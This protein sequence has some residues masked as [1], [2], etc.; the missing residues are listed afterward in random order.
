MIFAIVLLVV[1]VAMAA[2]GFKLLRPKNGDIPVNGGGYVNA[3]PQERSPAAREAGRILLGV[4]LIMVV[5]G[6]VWLLTRILMAILGIVLVVVV[7]AAVL[8]F[9]KKR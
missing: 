2:L 1:G 6:L 3:G 4:G 8:F 7:I 5:G 9:M